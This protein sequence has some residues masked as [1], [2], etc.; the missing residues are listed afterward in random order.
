MKTIQFPLTFL[1]SMATTTACDP[2]SSADFFTI[3]LLSTAAVFILTLSAPD[4][5]AI[6]TSSGVLIPPPTVKGMDNTLAVSL[7]TLYNAFLAS[8]VAVISKKT[9]SSAPSSSYRLA[10]LTGSPFNW[11]LRKFTPLTTLPS[12]TSRQAIILFVVILS[13]SCFLFHCLLFSL[14]RIVLILRP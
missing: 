1:T 6:D 8:I 10:R 9:I 2:N 3:W 13:P 5:N 7:M 11:R 14:L 4:L 12:F